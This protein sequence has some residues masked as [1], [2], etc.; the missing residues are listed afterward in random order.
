MSLPHKKSNDKS[1]D[2]FEKKLNLSIKKFH[3][4]ISKIE[5][6]IKR[7]NFKTNLDMCSSSYQLKKSIRLMEFL[8][9][10]R[11]LQSDNMTTE[12]N[13]EA[14]DTSEGY[15]TSDTSSPKKSLI[16][17][18]NSFKSIVPIII[19]HQV[20]EPDQVDYEECKVTLIWNLFD[21]TNKK[22]LNSP[23]SVIDN[24]E[25]YEIYSSCLDSLDKEDLYYKSLEK[26]TIDKSNDWEIIGT[27]KIFEPAVKW[28]F[29][30]LNYLIFILIFILK[31]N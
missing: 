11:P 4:K 3:K 30:K 28:Y 24:I 16:L 18:E 13:S 2:K 23:N 9:K 10:G 15:F 20:S 29:F 31:V 1:I 8:D 6:T 21:L 26:K 25:F 14:E 12:N 5:R 22:F 27:V 7:V 19:M 17:K